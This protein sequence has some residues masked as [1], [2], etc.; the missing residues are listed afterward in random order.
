MNDYIYLKRDNPNR[1]NEL[2]IRYVKKD[3][4]NVKLNKIVLNKVYERNEVKEKVIKKKRPCDIIQSSSY[5]ERKER[6]ES[7]KSV[8]FNKNKTFL[9]LPPM[10]DK[11]N[12]E[13]KEKEKSFLKGRA[14]K[15]YFFRGNIYL[16]PIE[17]R[18]KNKSMIYI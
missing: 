15:D 9:H 8:D 5:N 6:K 7:I 11:K 16:D 17:N 10:L 2:M 3:Y 12:K 1:I 13:N 4:K 18:F 14:Y